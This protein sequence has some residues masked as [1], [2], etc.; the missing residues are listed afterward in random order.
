MAPSSR[1]GGW[2][3]IFGDGWLRRWRCGRRRRCGRGGG[4]FR[5]GGGGAARL[6]Q[7]HAAAQPA[8]ERSPS[9][10]SPTRGP[11]RSSSA[12]R[13]IRCRTLRK[14]WRRLDSSSARK[15]K[16]FTITMQNA[17]VQQVQTGAAE[18]LP[19]QHR[20]DFD[21]HAGRSADTRAR[22][23]TLRRPTPPHA[24]SGQHLGG[25]PL[26]RESLTRIQQSIHMT[27]KTLS[28]ADP[29][30][31][32]RWLDPSGRRPG[33]GPG[34]DRTRAPAEFGGGIGGGLRRRGGG[35]RRGERRV[36]P[37]NTRIRPCWAMP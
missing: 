21:L 35:G 4:G 18:S 37:G 26:R 16:A 28:I 31:V 29:H 14:W 32:L 2:V 30:P 8:V 24:Q 27:I 15:Q 13:R 20:A 33:T 1:A 23:P 12:P 9:W 36:P 17:D 22:R 6:E 7:A 25:G 5:G 11:T 34:N 3:A 19:K 10:R